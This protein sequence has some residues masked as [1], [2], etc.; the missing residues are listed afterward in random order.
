MY[1]YKERFE[2][3]RAR[4]E[5]F[6]YSCDKVVTWPSLQMLH[7]KHVPGVDSERIATKKVQPFGLLVNSR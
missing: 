2:F 4:A 3:E 6:A 7:S 5:D 1:V